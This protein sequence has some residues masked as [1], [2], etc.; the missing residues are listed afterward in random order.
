[1]QGLGASAKQQLDKLTRKIADSLKM[2]VDAQFM[3]EI[4]DEA[5]RLIYTR[6]KLGYGVNSQGGP[7]Q[8]LLPLSQ[9]YINYR[10]KSGKLDQS[11]GPRK[12]NLTFTGQL[13]NSIKVKKSGVLW[14]G[15]IGYRNDGLSNEEVANRVTAAGRPFMFLSNLELGKLKRFA[16]NN[17]DSVFKQRFK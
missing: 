8:K 14:V 16:S 7:R 15:P 2:T 1:M 11:T 9:N 10:K 17:F 5:V 3:K 6:T 12:S 13:L 4:G